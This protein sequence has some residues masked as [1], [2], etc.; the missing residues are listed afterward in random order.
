MKPLTNFMSST[1]LAANNIS[2]ADANSAAENS[3]KTKQHFTVGLQF[4]RL[5]INLIPT[6]QSPEHH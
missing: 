1:F 2:S 4:S 6:L 3:F 5:V